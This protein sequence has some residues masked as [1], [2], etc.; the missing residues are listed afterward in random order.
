MKKVLLGLLAVS[1]IAFGASNPGD[2]TPT[3]ANAKG[4]AGVPLQVKASV[5]PAS[6][7]L[8]LVDE[9]N[10]VIDSLVFDHG[11]LVQKGQ[12]KLDKIVILKRTDNNAFSATN[13]MTAKFVATNNE[14]EVVDGLNNFPLQGATDTSKVL[15]SELAY[16]SKD[17]TVPTN[18]TFVRTSVVS[19][20]VVP[21][22]QAEGLYIGNGTFTATL[23][24]NAS[25]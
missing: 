3:T 18:A 6:S 25:K 21:A 12:S 13:D 14:K 19:K 9:N 5:V 24:N 17:I 16:N 7:R 20:V 23:T 22:D 1:A 8:V 4:E 2:N 10:K 15:N 11:N